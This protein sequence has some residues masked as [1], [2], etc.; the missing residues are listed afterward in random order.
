[1]A[2]SAAPAAAPKA[3]PLIPLTKEFMSMLGTKDEKAIYA[4]KPVFATRCERISSTNKLLERAVLFS[5]DGTLRLIDTADGR[6]T[7]TLE[8]GDQ[9]NMDWNITVV[10][11]RDTHTLELGDQRNMDWNITVVADREKDPKTHTH[12]VRIVI[13]KSNT[14]AAF[15]S[16]DEKDSTEEIVLQFHCARAPV[17]VNFV[18]MLRLKHR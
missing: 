14:R 3:F 12:G 16:R 9:R 10:A 7:H 2:A 5:Q 6:I 15:E 11:D 18:A 4:L 8:L 17:A 13:D 1:M